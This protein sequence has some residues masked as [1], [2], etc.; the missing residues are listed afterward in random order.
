[1]DREDSPLVHDLRTQVVHARRFSLVQIGTVCLWI[2]ALMYILSFSINLATNLALLDLADYMPKTTAGV[3]S[4]FYAVGSIMVS[5]LLLL[6]LRYWIP[7]CIAAIALQGITG[8]IGFT[9]AYGS[10]LFLETPK[11]VM[12][13]TLTIQ[14]NTEWTSIYF[15][16]TSTWHVVLEAG[17]SPLPHFDMFIKQATW[18]YQRYDVV[19]LD[20]RHAFAWAIAQDYAYGTAGMMYRNASL[21]RIGSG[22]DIVLKPL[23][24]NR[25]LACACVPIVRGHT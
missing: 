9:L 19:W 11:P 5:T 18:E 6:P 16:P 12:I 10:M 15:D 7:W 20:T 14:K 22:S 17:S 21:G 23:C 4:F 8:R 1:M 13:N 2:I 3:V 25:V 24:K